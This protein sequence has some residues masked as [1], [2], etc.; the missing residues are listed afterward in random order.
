MRVTSSQLLFLGPV[1]QRSFLSFRPSNWTKS[2]AQYRFLSKDVGTAGLENNVLGFPDNSPFLKYT[3]DALVENF[4]VESATLYKT[5][6]YFL[7]EAF[8][9]YPYNKDIALIH[10]DYVGGDGS[11]VDA[12]IKDIPSDS[13]WDDNQVR[14]NY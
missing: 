10:W 4:P 12:I 11:S 7:K 8:L 2:S 1:F 5:G 14:L 9:Q 6:P 13:E 3:L